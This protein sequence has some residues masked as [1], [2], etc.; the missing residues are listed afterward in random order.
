VLSKRIPVGAATK[1]GAKR[2]FN[3][4]KTPNTNPANVLVQ[5]EME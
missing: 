5:R 3:K 2:V 4:E 1:T